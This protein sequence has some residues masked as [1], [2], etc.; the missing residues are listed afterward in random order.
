MAA[1]EKVGIEIELM[2]ADEAY[3]TLRNIDET[4][5]NLG[6]KKT[7]IKL[8]D[9]SIDSIDNQIKKIQD[10]LDALR[11]AKKV[12]VITPEETEEA[13]RLE[14]QLRLIKRG[15]KDGTAEA[16]S[17]K[18]EFNSISSKVAHVGSALQ[19]FGNAMTT[20]T[21]PFR[22]VTDGILMG[23]GYKL[24]NSFTEGFERGFTRYDTM[25][26]YPKIMAAFGY[27]AKEAEDSINA[28]DL[29][30]RGL[31]TGLDE[32]VDLAQRFT[33]TTGDIARVQ[34]LPLQPTMRSSHQCLRIHRSIRE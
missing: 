1:T 10:R 7:M 11:A 20:L 13:K 33:A 26:K 14:A 31:P 17:F 21:S 25:K 12:G 34:N 23:T 32:M 24:L 28:L 4:V 29:S 8:D 9:G 5:R 27:S 3:K 18:Q 19:S 16:R 2:N 15:L 30:V 22:R 6:R